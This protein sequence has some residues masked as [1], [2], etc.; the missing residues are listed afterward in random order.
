[1]GIIAMRTQN[2]LSLMIPRQFYFVSY[3]GVAIYCFILAHSARAQII[4]DSTTNTSVINDCQAG[5]DITGGIRGGDNLFHSF[6]DFNLAAGESAYFVDPGV[7]HIFS[8]ITGNNASHISGTLGIS[9]GNA[10]LWLLNPN[11]IIFGT[12]ATLD[13]NGSFLATTADSI[14]FG[15]RHSFTALPNAEE[16]LAL[17]NVNPSALFFNQMG[18]NQ[19]I[20]I[21]SRTILS[22]PNGQSINL[23]GGQPT[24]D[25]PGVSLNSSGLSAPFG[26]VEIGAIRDSGTIEID[27]NFYTSF[28]DDTD[29]GDISL[30]QGSG[31]DVSGVGG[32]NVSLQGDD[33]S[34]TGASN[35]FSRTMGDGDG[36]KIEIVA[37]NLTLSE[38]STISTDSVNSGKST[39]IKITASESVN[40]VGS[41]INEFQQLL[42]HL[43]SE[44]FSGEINNTSINTTA[45]ADGASGDITIDSPNLNLTNGAWI[46]ATTTNA[47]DAGN[48]DIDVDRT[49]SLDGSGLI[50]GTDLASTGNAGSVTVDSENLLIQ[51]GGV[52]SS[53][54]LG[55]GRGGNITLDVADSIALRKSLT[56]GF[57]PTGVFTNT[58]F[59]DGAAGDLMVNTSQLIMTGG[60]ELSSGSGGITNRGILPFGGQGGNITVSATDSI[61]IAGISNDDVFSSGIVNRTLSSSPAGDITIH[62]GKLDLLDEGIISAS[63]IGDG[64]GGNLTI[65]ADESI[66]LKGT[67]FEN[68][69]NLFQIGLRG[70]IEAQNLTGGLLSNTQT[71]EAGSTRITSPN[72]I[73]ENGALISTSTFG[74][75]AGGN[76]DISAQDIKVSA[77][78]LTSS[79]VDIGRAGN[80][81]IETDRLATFNGGL[82]TTSSV[83]L[84]NAGDL[85]INADDSIQLI[86]RNN[87]SL[88]LSGLFTN[89]LGLSYSGN[90]EVNTKDLTIAG[91]A[92]I[93][94]VNSRQNQL[95]QDGAN[96]IEFPLEEFQLD[97]PRNIIINAES[98][99]IT[100]TPDNQLFTRNISSTTTS[101][102]P[103]SNI[104]INTSELAVADFSEISVSSSGKGRAGNL[105]IVADSVNLSNQSTLNASTFSG[106]GGNIEL[107]VRDLLSLS[108]STIE[109]DAFG[110]GNGG[111]IVIDTDFVI[112]SSASDI[113]ARAVSGNGGNIEIEATD[114]FLTSNSKI[115]A[116][117]QLG[118][119]G[120][121]NIET[122]EVSDR[123]SLVKLPETTLQA[124]SK[125]FTACGDRQNTNGV[126]FYTGR[127]GLPTNLL[128]NYT[129]GD[130]NII[131]DL[132]IPQ[133]LKMLDE[134]ANNSWEFIQATPKIVEA[135]TWHVNRQG[136]VELVAENESDFTIA[137]SCPV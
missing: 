93:S 55:E 36:G 71:G 44:S 118:I 19:P 119:D 82:I 43:T 34:L 40:L 90:L 70:E 111:N 121:V 86:D 73:L 81:T 17:L 46:L 23:L 83:G 101:P 108:N 14:Q 66:Y 112:A 39:E 136:N 27:E 67:G 127:G 11:G 91:E 62:T 129:S 114:L 88:V 99:N 52:I 60:G 56:N 24:E 54:T 41:D 122:F 125:I 115:T 85:T 133:R 49:V 79:T 106:R 3:A 57:I 10:N 28:S 37:N 31:I 47:G 58:V 25:I 131:A 74:T 78:L 15:D 29:K 84:G 63:S 20:N 116:S 50:T 94:A 135:A 65:V 126:F 87:S 8:R 68:L 80:I 1:M 64:G 72:L 33:V 113:S 92:Q 110:I 105:K 5:C 30:S 16:N 7:T 76:I 134:L 51:N 32:G 59:G 22:V 120:Q 38:N 124:D 95:I 100:G 107:E 128:N 13:V 98:I 109:T 130:R 102:F 61:R 2:R 18:Q 12:G 4:P 45:F 75:R 117:S 97:S 42:D 6:D 77:S 48:I 21:D 9:G 137:A 104:S 89:S 35:I 26:S 132:D 69:Q 123:N 96:N 53:S 103:A